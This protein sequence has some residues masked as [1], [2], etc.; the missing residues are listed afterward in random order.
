MFGRATHVS[1]GVHPSLDPFVQNTVCTKVEVVA[2][3]WNANPANINR[4]LQL[5]KA[6]GQEL[7]GLQDLGASITLICPSLDG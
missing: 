7:Q 2:A 5:V 1:Q 3:I 4:L 6:N